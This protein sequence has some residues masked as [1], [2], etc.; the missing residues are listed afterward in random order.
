MERRERRDG[1]TRS[2]RKGK[3]ERIGLIRMRRRREGLR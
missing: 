2:R 1:E 3:E